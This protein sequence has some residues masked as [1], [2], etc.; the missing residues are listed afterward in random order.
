MVHNTTTLDLCTDTRTQTTRVCYCS[1]SSQHKS[2]HPFALSPDLVTS[3]GRFPKQKSN[4]IFVIMNA[5][6]QAFSFGPKS[7]PPN[8]KSSTA[9]LPSVVQLD[10]QSSFFLFLLLNNNNKKNLSQNA[11][12]EGRAI[13]L[14]VGGD[15]C[16]FGLQLRKLTNHHLKRVIGTYCPPPPNKKE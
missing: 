14:P 11:A 1:I 3:F 7:K 4:R 6:T 10:H 16:A 12:E 5:G 15:W 13:S 9:A 2:A 8:R